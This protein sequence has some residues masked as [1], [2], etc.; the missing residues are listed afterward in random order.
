MHKYTCN[1]H[2]AGLDNHVQG[3]KRIEMAKKT[4]HF[5]WNVVQAR[6][7]PGSI[8]TGLLAGFNSYMCH[9]S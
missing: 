6:A 7:F 1:L 2:V 9:F 8:K 4:A 5:V 3:E